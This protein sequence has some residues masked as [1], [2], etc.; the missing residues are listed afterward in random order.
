[1]VNVLRNRLDNAPLSTFNGS[2]QN[3]FQV[4]LFS[5]D[6]LNTSS[7]Q[8]VLKNEGDNDQTTYFDIDYIVYRAGLPNSSQSILLDN[9]DPSFRYLPSP[10]SWL[11]VNDSASFGNSLHRTQ[12]AG[13]SMQIRFTGSAI[14]VYG[15]MSSEGGAYLCSVDDGP[16]ALYSTN[17][18]LTANQQLL[19][20]ADRLSADGAEHTMTLTRNGGGSGDYWLDIDY[21][22]LYG[23]SPY[24][25]KVWLAGRF[26]LL[27]D[28]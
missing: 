28:G 25:F 3:Q 27:F 18:K 1:M 26:S 2:S 14:G 4:V 24:V 11:P 22:Q 12:T 5:A 9:S 13:A 17:W 19:C 7:H 21:A 8:L 15:R 20:F 23:V 6:N 10:S 16:A